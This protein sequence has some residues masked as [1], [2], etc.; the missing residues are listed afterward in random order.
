MSGDQSRSST[1]TTAS[2]H[3]EFSSPKGF[4]TKNRDESGS[5]EHES[6]RQYK[7]GLRDQ[8][9]GILMSSWVDNAPWSKL[10]SR[11]GMNADLANRYLDLQSVPECSG[12]WFGLLDAR[13]QYFPWSLAYF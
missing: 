5:P 8:Y 6:S 12:T 11:V 2:T 13:P 3:S 4:G 1:V 10:S 7:F 9:E